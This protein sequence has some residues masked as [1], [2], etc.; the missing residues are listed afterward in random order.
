MGESS[1]YFNIE[2]LKKKPLWQMTGEELDYLI[3]QAL[4]NGNNVNPMQDQ[5]ADMQDQEADVKPLP[6]KDKYVYGID[7]LANLFGCSRA[8]ATRIKASGKIDK[9]ITQIGRQIIIDTDCA[10]ELAKRKK[11]RYQSL[12]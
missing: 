2:E 8:T 5:E 11:T 9:A 4:Q 12:K 10:L 7:G 1:Q 6:V 3:C